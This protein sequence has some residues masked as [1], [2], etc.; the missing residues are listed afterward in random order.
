[1]L[2]FFGCISTALITHA[3]I[4]VYT[5]AKNIGGA[6]ELK[7]MAVKTDAS[8]NV[9]TAGYF[10]V[11]GDFDPGAGSEILYA[12]GDFDIYVTKS[13]ASGKFIWAKGI[14]DVGV[15][16]AYGVA[17]DASGNVYVAGSFSGTVDFDPG[18]GTQ[19]LTSAGGTDIFVLKLNSAGDYVWAR[20][21]GGPTDDYAYGLTVD[22]SGN[23][24]TTGY[25]T[26]IADFDP[27]AVSKILASTG[28][29]D[30]F[31]SKLTSSGNYA[32]AKRMGGTD[33]DQGLAITS[34]ASG[35]VYATGFFSDK[36]E[37][38]DGASFY[39][40]TAVGV[41]DIFI[42]KFDNSGNFQW[43]KGIGGTSYDGGQGIAL[44]ASNNVYTVGYFRGYADFDPGTT[45]SYM[46]AAVTDIFIS[47]LTSAGKFVWARQM[48]GTIPNYGNPVAVDPTGGVYVTGI[49]GGTTDFDPSSSKTF[50]L[51]SNGYE[52]VFISKFD[53]AGN[54]SWA[55][56]IG[57]TK[58]D[59]S[60]ALTMDGS[61]TLLLTGYFSGTCDFDPAFATKGNLSASPAGLSDAY[62]AKYKVVPTGISELGK[63]YAVSIYP[64]PNTGQ[65]TVKIPAEAA[66]NKIEVYNVLGS[67]VYQ[68]NKIALLNNIDLTTVGNGL[69]FVKIWNEEGLLATEKIIKQ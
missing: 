19:N 42:E 51:V 11:G 34:D 21:M 38:N 48:N 13:D 31:I 59:Y 7:S 43:A 64:N 24:F 52:D 60:T 6:G 9:Y 69:Y 23:P 14:G 22:A 44:D 1:M 46:N 35:N 3:Q 53:D 15:D 29:A 8:G 18:A 65:I 57:G 61:K 32:W 63:N 27:S 62:T 54:F 5:W 49:F 50:N 36:A 66:A 47:K 33:E 58:Y 67:L 30:I 25:F 2:L 10:S 12:T 28:K 39:N 16:N 68:N 45:D 26:G 4:P 37:F 20:G 56:G 40:L 55:A 41:K 17:V